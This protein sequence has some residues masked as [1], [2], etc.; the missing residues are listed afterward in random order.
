MNIFEEFENQDFRS[1]LYLL[2]WAI[3]AII[4]LGLLV[5]SKVF[6]NVYSDWVWFENLG[7]L[8][9]YLTI[10]Q[11]KISLFSIGVVAFLSVSLINL[12]IAKRF[13]P[14]GVSTEAVLNF[15][16]DTLNLA[17]QALRVGII[18][19]LVVLA[20]VFGS[21]TLGAWETTLR[22]ANSNI[23]SIVDPLFNKDVSFY[24]FQMPWY[25]FL[26]SWGVALLVVNIL[27]VLGTYGAQFALGGFQFRLSPAIK[28]HLSGLG[29]ILLIVLAF[30]YW[31]DLQELVFSA[32]G[33]SYGAGYADI[34]VKMPALK[35]LIALCLGG[36]FLMAINIY[37]KNVTLPV[38]IFGLWFAAYVLGTFA[39]PSAVQRFQVD[40]NEYALESPYIE[41]SISMTRKAFAI[42]GSRVK[43]QSFLTNAGELL[44]EEILD[45]NKATIDNIRLWDD[46]PL[47]DVY[48]Q[49]QFFRLQYS[50]LDID[51]DR[52]QIGDEYRQVMIGSRELV[53]SQLP[54]TAQTWINRKLQYTHGYGVAMS[55]VTEFT[56]DG[57]PVFMIKDIPPKSEPGA[58]L[59]ERPQIYYGEATDDWVIVG[60]KTP[61]FD[62]PANQGAVYQSYKGPGIFLD[63]LLKKFVF[64][65]KFSD[66]N[67][68]ITSEVTPE[69]QILYYRGIEERVSRVAPFLQLDED[70]YMVVANNQLYWIQDAYTTSNRFPYSE[71]SLG[72]TGNKFNYMRNSAKIVVNAYDGSMQFYVTDSDDAIINTYND[73]FPDLFNPIEDMPKDIRS[74]IRY[75]EDFFSIQAD[76]YLKFH[77]TDP[78]VFY[79]QEDLWEFPREIFFGENAQTMEPYYLIMKLPGE[80][81]E[82]FVLIMPFTPLNKPNL[83][84]WLAARNDGINYGN[85]LAF[86]FPNE[87]QID[88]PQQVDARIDV[89]PKISESFTLWSQSGSDVLRGNLLVIPVGN[90]ILYAEP[91][92]LQAEDIEYPQLTRVVL[93]QQGQEPMMEPTLK[94]S[95]KGIIG[96]R[97]LANIDRSGEENGS[98]GFANRL[99][100]E[101]NRAMLTLKNLQDQF[102]S[103]SSTLEQLVELEKEESP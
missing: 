93:V 96:E 75:P 42:D 78:Q 63:S 54:E 16:L 81:K 43:E 22:F 64:A 24:M 88:G 40:P 66:L 30:G 17:R 35:F 12:F 79:N 18:I 67:L 101:F 72:L 15:S 65:I 10:L 61:E 31:L 102:G 23:F 28:A 11:T 13:S 71:P 70:P 5:I 92:Y 85:L 33:A 1:R 84:G 55:P 3:P 103:L 49:I 27:L 100:S 83:V 9:V 25:R 77:M 68:L 98:S 4:I 97:S 39:I 51:I 45:E 52:Y 69:S 76:K 58:P 62:H 29:A 80:V 36:S 32:N 41:R 91:V 94:E 34:T 20:F 47:R 86:T 46:R 48:N 37:L 95:L 2:K 74:H 90:S 59:V 14:S 89:N 73:V 82:E 60:S 19:L 99:Q 8:S 38:I 87:R 53:Q 50:F 44:T 57:L 56:S 7:F 21:S 6:S 26:Y